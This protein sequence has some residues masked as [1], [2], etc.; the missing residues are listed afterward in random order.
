MDKNEIVKALE[1]VIK[2]LDESGINYFIG[3]SIA[4]SAYGIARATL[5]VDMIVQLKQIQA[6]ILVEKLSSEYYIDAEMI[7]NAIKDKSSF[8][9]IHLESMLKMA[10][11]ISQDL[12]FDLKSFE[13]KT[14][15][16]LDESD[17]SI[18]IYL[19]SAEDIILSKLNWF[20]LSNQTSE[21]Q[22]Q[23]IMGVIKVQKN[24][25]D[26]E[27]LKHWAIQLDLFS[28]LQKAFEQS[29]ESL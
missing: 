6:D 21:K 19:S 18:K 1:P 26:K 25:L 7:T 8:N 14:Q 4:S 15:N 29:E 10:F 28:L 3:G 11:F 24:N 17:E 23:D 9:I 22:W 2:I 27:Y 5:D 16:N 12:A 13:R 20:N